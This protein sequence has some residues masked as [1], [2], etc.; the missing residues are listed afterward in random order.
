LAAERAEAALLARHSGWSE[1]ISLLKAALKRAR[2]LGQPFETA[3]TSLQLADALV[4]GGRPADATRARSLFR[5]AAELF[6][7][8]GAE[9]LVRRPASTAARSSGGSERVKVGT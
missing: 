8:L 6:G 5:T 3:W 4:G 9:H 1:A 2:Q 7:S